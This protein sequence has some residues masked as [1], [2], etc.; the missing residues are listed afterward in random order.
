MK[1]TL[2]GPR[3]PMPLMEWRSDT[4]KGYWCLVCGTETH[5]DAIDLVACSHIQFYHPL[6]E[7]QEQWHKL[8]PKWWQIW[9]W[10]R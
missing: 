6:E 7:L 5:F 10:L 2:L 1:K 4:L 9:R 8:R 3:A